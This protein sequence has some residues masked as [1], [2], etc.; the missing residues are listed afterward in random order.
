MYS[1]DNSPVFLDLITISCDFKGTVACLITIAIAGLNTANRVFFGA[2]VHDELGF[3]PTRNSFLSLTSTG[4][5]SSYDA[6]TSLALL[7][8]K[9]FIDMLLVLWQR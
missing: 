6:Y 9:V 1:R 7:L 3:S 2:R 5:S 8:C 4:L